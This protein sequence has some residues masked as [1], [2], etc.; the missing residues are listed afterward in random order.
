MAAKCEEAELNI[1]RIDDVV[2]RTGNTFR[3][4]DIIAMEIKILDFFAWHG[5]LP[6]HACCSHRAAV[7]VIAPVMFLDYYLEQAEQLTDVVAELS[8]VDPSR[9]RPAMK[10]RALFFVE[11]ALQG[12]WHQSFNSSLTDL[13]VRL[14]LPAELRAVAHR[15]RRCDRRSRVTW[16]CTG[17]VCQHAGCLGHHIRPRQRLC[18]GHAQV[19]GIQCRY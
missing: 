9:M 14:P 8:I 15:R 13:I 5:V 6:V 2:V 16:H 19:R 10:E 1:P 17:V 18:P 3:K 7:T 11:T 12:M 4:R